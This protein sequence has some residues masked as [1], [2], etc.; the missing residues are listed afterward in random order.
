MVGRGVKVWC[1][2]CRGLRRWLLRGERSCSSSWLGGAPQPQ[3][4][5]LKAVESGASRGDAHNARLDGEILI[6]AVAGVV[7]AAKA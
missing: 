2:G 6:V 3:R 4:V 7:V 1:D 5:C